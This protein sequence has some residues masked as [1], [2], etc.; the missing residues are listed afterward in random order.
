MLNG[1]LKSILMAS[2]SLA[3]FGCGPIGAR[4][5]KPPI[6]E[7][8]RTY[9]GAIDEESDAISQGQKQGESKL[10]DTW[11]AFS[12]AWIYPGDPACNAPTTYKNN[13]IMTLNAEYLAVDESGLVK[14]LDVNTSGCNG[15]SVQNA[16]EV[17]AHS[18][19]QF[20]TI[21]SSYQGFSKLVN[22]AANR[23]AAVGA[24]VSFL[25]KIEF[26]GAELDFES[27]SKWTQEDYSNYKSF[28]SELGNALRKN[29]MALKVDGPPISN[30][31]D[32]SLYLWKYEDFD[33][34]P[35]DSIVVMAYDYQFDCGG[36]SPV[37]PNAWVKDVVTWTKSKIA[38]VNRIVIGIPAYGY[39]GVTGAYEITI[40]T[41]LQSKAFPGYSKATRDP[42]SNEMV[43]NHL[44]VSYVYQDETSLNL[45]RT[46]VESL[47]IKHISVWHLGGNLWFTGKTEPGTRPSPTPTPTPPPRETPP[48]AGTAS[49]S[50]DL[51]LPSK[52]AT[53]QGLSSEV[54]CVMRPD[55]YFE[56]VPKNGA[57][58]F[59]NAANL[60]TLELYRTR[61][62]AKNCQGF[63]YS[64]SC[65]QKP[66][67]S[68]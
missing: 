37:A 22:S 61:I 60:N 44:G 63:L 28:V 27:Y 50:V 46:L 32:Q 1:R 3:L 23:S 18:A 7:Q 26:A 35:V 25:Q 43:W 58:T 20:V 65:T 39:H 57:T 14:I 10:A 12:Q 2:T 5:E 47:G 66:K 64:L 15:Y 19:K 33:R 9:E 45:K 67:T 13:S 51:S 31:K 8:S 52:T 55:T 4:Q 49:C 16:A 11:S 42:S 68:P 54:G 41:L 30:A 59:K 36:G 29:S 34:L 17:K 53:I 62:G 56:K 40:D 38:D 21:S 24:I 6:A 48:P